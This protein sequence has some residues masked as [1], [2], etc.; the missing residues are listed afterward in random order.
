MPSSNALTS[1]FRG[2]AMR[3]MQ[4]YPRGASPAT[5]Q[6]LK[7]HRLMNPTSQVRDDEA[8]ARDD[9]GDLRDT[10][11]AERDCDADRRDARAT[12]RDEDAGSSIHDLE[13]DLEAL[14]SRLRERLDHGQDELDDA[15]V[16][17]GLSPA[18]RQRLRAH[19]TQ[20]RRLADDDL[21]VAGRLLEQAHE[22]AGRAMPDRYAADRDRRDAR[23]DRVQAAQDG[24]AAASDRRASAGDREQSDVERQLVNVAEPDESAV[25]AGAG[26]SSGSLPERVRQALAKSRRRIDDS[27]ALLMREITT[28]PR[29]PRPR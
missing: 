24:H 21:A 28:A 10:A 9:A 27:R 3:A 1:T 17:A 15:L 4:G 19:A 23:R 11:A 22:V 7:G 29:A 16:L 12:S 18:G 6:Q 26:H 8:F 14:H 5:P 13:R 20:Q 2:S 25:P